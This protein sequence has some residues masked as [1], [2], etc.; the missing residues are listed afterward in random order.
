MQQIERKNSILRIHAV[1]ARNQETMTKPSL[2]IERLPSQPAGA[3][4]EFLAEAPEHIQ[5][6]VN[7]ML[8]RYQLSFSAVSRR[9]LLQLL[10]GEL[11]HPSKPANILQ[12]LV[13]SYPGTPAAVLEELRTCGHVE[14][15]VRIAEHA[16]TSEETLAEL[17]CD[18]APE[19]RA[20]VADNANASI[21]TQ[22]Q[23]AF[24]PSVDVRYRQAENS[25]TA[26]RIL[27]HHL[28]D[29]N[30]YIARRA[31]MT[32]ERITGISVDTVSG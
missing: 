12:K 29:E 28:T 31:R 17:G 3:L 22:W 32:L 10:V 9:S 5:L 14:I 1:N 2:N 24:D 19:V 4:R 7:E 27:T 8:L 11:L 26:W 15:L 18:S 25:C 16:N 30:P 6:V 20:A 13:A 23:L 21:T